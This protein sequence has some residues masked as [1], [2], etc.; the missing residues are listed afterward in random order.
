MSL[1]QN[2]T[3][4]DQHLTCC[5]SADVPRSQFRPFPPLLFSVLMVPIL[6]QPS[7]LSL[8]VISAGKLLLIPTSSWWPI[9]YIPMWSWTSPPLTLPVVSV[10]LLHCELDDGRDSCVSWSLLYSQACHK[11][12]AINMLNELR[13][14]FSELEGF[15]IVLIRRN[16]PRQKVVGPG[17]TWWSNSL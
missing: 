17:T 2:L 1:Q 11:V 15:V 16:Y 4:A 5:S 13:I 9:L 7:D 12:D 6:I 10:P 8:D 14:E 3:L